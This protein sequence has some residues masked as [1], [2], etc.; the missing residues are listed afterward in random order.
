[1]RKIVIPILIIC[2]VVVACV[3]IIIDGKRDN[4]SK[5]VVVGGQYASTGNLYGTNTTT[6]F[7]VATTTAANTSSSIYITPEVDQIDLNI[8]VK[9]SSTT[10]RIDWQYEFSDD[11]DT[12]FGEDAYSVSGSTVT[13]QAATTT[14]TWIPADVGA[15]AKNITIKDVASKFFRLKVNRGVSGATASNNFAVWIQGIYKVK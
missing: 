14:H 11:N 2:L 5:S 6:P 8:W 1:M 3:Y 12:W 9:A 4:E 10:A 15:T 7:Y 13:H